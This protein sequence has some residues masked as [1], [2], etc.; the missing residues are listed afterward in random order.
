MVGINRRTTLIGA[1]AAGIGAGVG[2][3]ATL[4]GGS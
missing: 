2:M 3:D 1:G 4:A